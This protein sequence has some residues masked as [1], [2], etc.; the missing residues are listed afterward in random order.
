MCT[1]DNV[2]PPTYRASQSHSPDN[3]YD[4]GPPPRFCAAQWQFLEFHLDTV[5]LVA[6]AR[7]FYVVILCDAVGG[8]IC[9]F[10]VTVAGEQCDRILRR[11][12]Q[13]QLLSEFQVP[14]AAGR[15]RNLGFAP[16]DP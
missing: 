7:I 16:L 4:S 9:Q 5:A 10:G 1:T 15:T 13:R 2:P 6:G 14:S 11:C 3:G 12:W 8:C